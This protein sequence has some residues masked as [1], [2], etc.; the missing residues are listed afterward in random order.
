VEY[1]SFAADLVRGGILSDPWLDGRERFRLEPVVLSAAAERRLY[2]AAEALAGAFDEAVRLC[3]ENPSLA[4]RFVGLSPWQRLM[5][6]A[7]AP[8]WHG[9]ARADVFLT[10]AGP[11]ICELN[12]DTPSGEAEAVLLGR[13]AAATHPHCRDAC[14]TLEERFCA[15][16]EA[17]APRRPPRIGIVYPTELTEDLSMIALYCGWFEARGWPVLLGSPFNLRHGHRTGVT[18]FG[19][20]CDV[21]VRHYKTDWWGERRPVWRNEA[22]YPDPAALEEP[23]LLLLGAQ[24]LGRCAVVNPFGAIVA[25][26]KRL[27]ALLWEEI[28]RLSAPARQAVRAFLPQTVRLEALDDSTLIAERNDWVLKSDYGCEGVEVLVGRQ[29]PE[30][31][32]ADALGQMIRSRWIAQRWFDGGDINYG[33]YLVAGEAAGIFSRVQAGPTDRGALTAPTLVSAS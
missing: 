3:R 13:A 32:W 5:W 2:E 33:V 24:L 16:I 11:Q 14:A 7:S 15:L 6:E 31:I 17:V 27:M 20:D 9:I 23:L 1:G 22:A 19:Q 29:T 25:Q 4:D 30:P 28:D 21:V 10:A 18:L 8:R 12:C 26:N